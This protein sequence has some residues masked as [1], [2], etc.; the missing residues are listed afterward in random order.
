MKRRAKKRRER[1]SRRRRPSPRRRRARAT[2]TISASERRRRRRCSPRRTTRSGN[3]A[4]S[5][6][7]SS[8]VSCTAN[9]ARFPRP[10][11]RGGTSGVRQGGE[12]PDGSIHAPVARGWRTRYLAPDDSGTRIS[13]SPPR[14]RTGGTR[15]GRGGERAVEDLEGRQIVSRAHALE[16]T[17]REMAGQLDPGAGAEVRHDCRGTEPLALP[18]PRARGRGRGR[19]AQALP[20]MPGEGPRGERRSRRGVRA[21]STAGRTATRAR[22]RSGAAS[23]QCATRVRGGPGDRARE[24]RKKR[25]KE[26]AALRRRRRRL[27]RSDR[28]RNA[29]PP[30]SRRPRKPPPSRTA[31]GE[32]SG[33]DRVRPRGVRPGAR[34]RVHHPRPRRA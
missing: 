23:G 24:A 9:V 20:L 13:P 29:R 30:R 31:R 2:R 34:A 12:G 32:S 22:G 11:V 1:G 14:R 25:Q 8:R 17:V 21:R 6:A 18:P 10:R 19:P 33:G 4:C 28:R 7:T 27:R 5:F 26:E 3:S 16:D 15:R